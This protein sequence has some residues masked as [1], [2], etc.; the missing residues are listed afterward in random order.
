MD[1]KSMVQELFGLVDARADM[2]KVGSFF[3]EDAIF[4]FAN[5]EPIQGRAKIQAVI[6]G[7]HQ[8]T[9]ACKHVFSGIWVIDDTV[10]CRGDCTFT[11]FDDRQVIIPFVDISCLAGDQIKHHQ[12]YA[13]LTPLATPAEEATQV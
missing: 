1:K 13:D 10:I 9:K 4:V 3:A 2:D 11:L 5:Q 8:A 7:I 6:E 12:V